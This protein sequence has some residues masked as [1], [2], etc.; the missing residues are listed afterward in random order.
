MGSRN[1]KLERLSR[2][3]LLDLRLCELD[4][5]LRDTWVEP[6]IERVIDELD[7]REIAHRPHFWLA[8]EWF[9]PD[10]IP[11][12][13][14]P[15]YLAH[16]RLMDLERSQMYEVEG[17]TRRECLML[18]RHEVGHAID[19]AYQLNRRKRWRQLFGSRATPYPEYYRPKP[20]S[21]RFV[22]HLGGW[23]AQSH[24]AE[25][26]AETFAVWLDPR[27]RWRTR[28]EG[29]PAMKKLEYVDELMEGIAGTKPK[30]KSRAKP[31]SL[32]KLRHT[33]RTH[34]QRKRTHYDVGYSEAYD[35]DLERLF[36]RDGDG[37]TAAS[38]L[39]RRRRIIRERV[40]R[41]TGAYEL[42][43][44]QFLKEVVGRCRELGLRV[45]GDEA[46]VVNEFTVMLAVHVTHHLR[47][48]HWHPM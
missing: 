6:L 40:A 16:K 30:P 5:E 10:G 36:D 45:Q 27:S 32:G 38:L 7:Q 23:Y 9:S 14:V 19:T 43:V 44:D 22:Q 8:D 2:D 11:G 21:K 48:S 28:Y 20:G 25:D 13:G 29:W 4:L 42:A 15:F 41:W 46:D 26:F 24:P 12:V 39:R 1:G 37:P 17:G 18:L 34:Y 47:A 35:A 33:L 31:Y 3:E